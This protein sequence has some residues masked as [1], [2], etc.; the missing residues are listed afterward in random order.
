[1]TDPQY[2]P[3]PE[4]VVRVDDSTSA[5]MG[6]WDQR[7]RCVAV[8]GKIGQSVQCSIYENRPSCCRSFQASY[9]NGQR[10]RRCDKARLA[11][12]LKALSGDDWL[13]RKKEIEL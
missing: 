3:P 1:M 12:G 11:R 2:S 4:Y 8:S 9:E 5:M 13:P 6:T 10:N 7:M